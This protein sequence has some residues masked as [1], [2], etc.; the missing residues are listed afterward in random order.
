MANS[1]WFIKFIKV[2]CCMVCCG[3]DCFINTLYDTIFVHWMNTILKLISDPLCVIH[4]YVPASNFLATIWHTA[5]SYHMLLTES[6]FKQVYLVCA[7]SWW[8]L[9]THM[10]LTTR[11]YSIQTTYIAT[12][13]AMYSYSNFLDIKRKWNSFKNWDKLTTK[14]TL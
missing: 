4:S 7:N 6:G 2:Y 8:V 10:H 5:N 1:F 14:L 9:N 12:Y 13:K 3:T 11:V